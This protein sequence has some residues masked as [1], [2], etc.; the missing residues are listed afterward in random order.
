MANKHRW[1]K[2]S[3]KRR[4]V[5]MSSSSCENCMLVRQFVKGIPTYYD[6]LTDIVTDRYAPKCDPDKK[7]A[8]I[9]QM[10]LL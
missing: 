6:H 7:E 10:K 2:N 8:R 1:G 5:D 9:E 3:G 4:I